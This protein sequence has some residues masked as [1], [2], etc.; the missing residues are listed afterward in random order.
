MRKKLVETL[1]A[2][3]GAARDINFMLFDNVEAATKPLGQGGQEAVRPVIP[4]KG[5]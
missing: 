1:E 3:G 5:D 4:L 2:E